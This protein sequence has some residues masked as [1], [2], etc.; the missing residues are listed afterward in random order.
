[1]P[2]RKRH[3][4]DELELISYPIR[5]ILTSL[6]ILVVSFVVIPLIF[7]HLATSQDYGIYQP[8]IE[9]VMPLYENLAKFYGLIGLI[10]C[11]LSGIWFYTLLR[12][13]DREE[14]I[15][16]DVAAKWLASILRE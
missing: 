6:F 13:P 8:I 1:M 3:Q 2:R 15:L 12:R 11:V 5:L 7:S 9:A 4:I 14:T 16:I 10:I